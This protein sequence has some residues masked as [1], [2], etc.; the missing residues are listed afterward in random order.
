MARPNRA[1]FCCSI[2]VEAI[3][4]GQSWGISVEA[5]WGFDSEITFQPICGG[6]ALVK[7][8]FCLLDKEVNPV[9]NALRMKN[10]QPKFSRINAL[11]N[12]FIEVMPEVKIPA[13]NSNRRPC[14]DREGLIHRLEKSQRAAI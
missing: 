11:H 3:D 5:D 9:W 4:H 2:S 14:F 8:E 6:K 10:L 12:H 1:G 13:R 7:W